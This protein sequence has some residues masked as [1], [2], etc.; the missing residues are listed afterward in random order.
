[1]RVLQDNHVHAVSDMLA[2]VGT[3]LHMIKDFAPGDNVKNVAAVI[4]DIQGSVQIKF[5]AFLL[6]LI[7]LNNQ[8]MRPE[9]RR[10]RAGRDYGTI[11]KT[12]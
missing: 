10:V 11:C 7:Q 5:I 2:G 9:L 3:V 8:L 1:M 12:L 6:H 4:P